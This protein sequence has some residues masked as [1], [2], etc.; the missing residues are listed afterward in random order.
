M[1]SGID[2]MKA[3]GSR[4]ANRGDIM[5]GGFGRLTSPAMN[6]IEYA[7]AKSHDMATITPRVSA[8]FQVV[9]MIGTLAALATTAEK[10]LY[11]RSAEPLAVTHASHFVMKEALEVTVSTTPMTAH[12]PIPKTITTFWTLANILMP[13]T[14]NMKPMMLKIVATRKA[15]QMLSMS[16]LA[17]P[18]QPRNWKVIVRPGSTASGART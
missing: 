10:F 11:T 18:D 2:G 17:G 8:Q 5:V 16:Q 13:K 7:Y 1:A 9:G 12:P 4:M 3:P 14:T 6:E 15:A